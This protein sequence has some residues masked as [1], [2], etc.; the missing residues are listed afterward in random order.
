MSSNAPETAAATDARQ[1][2]YRSVKLGRQRLRVVS[3][4]GAPGRTPVLFFNGI[5]AS[6]EMLTPLARALHDV[7]IIAFDVPGVGLSP[8]RALPY[9]LWM[10]A[11]LASRLL[12]HLG[13]GRVD[14]FGVSWGGALAQQFALQHPWRCRRLVLAATTQGALMVPGRLNVLKHFIS[15]RR[16]NDPEHRERI[17]GDIYGGQA[18][19]DPALM[20]SLQH[21][22]KPASRYA[23]LLQ[24]L[25]ITGWTSLPWLPLLPQRTL[26][27]AGNDD[28]VVP[29]VNARLMHLLIRGSRLHVFDDGHL[30][31]LSQPEATARVL[32]GFL[33]EAP[34]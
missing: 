3:W 28:P 7:P 18:R 20:R 6:L 15:P 14:V 16:H 2:S 17:A 23:Y 11:R 1:P 24:Q 33:G 29:L 5:G 31:V 8:S 22:I 4:P 27:M 13:V 32:Q 9:R 30:F 26:I 34:A 10:L 25:A 19:T 21:L 12:D